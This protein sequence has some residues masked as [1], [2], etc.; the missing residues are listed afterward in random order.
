MTEAPDRELHAALA[1]PVRQ[2]VLGLLRAG[3]ASAAELA[4][5]L[6]LHV[7]TVRFH[8]DQLERAGV[9]ARQVDRTP[10][11]GRPATRYRAVGLDAEQAREQMIDALAQALAGGGSSPPEDAVTAGRRWADTVTA[12]ADDPTVAITD[13]FGRLGFAPEPAGD[14][15]R[16]RACPFRAAARH[17][18]QVV[19]RV[20]LG[21]ALGLAERAAP[22]HAVRVGLVP[23]AGPD[24]CLITLDRN[25][26]SEP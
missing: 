8:L 16:L 25:P 1:S 19:C 3:P 7:T 21:L 2:G 5:R 6:D 15:I 14:E 26:R 11:R 22:S 9:V 23:F 4:A 20:H 24:L 12:D 18:P 10:R 13:V 17:T